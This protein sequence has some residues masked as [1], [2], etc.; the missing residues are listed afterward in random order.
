M[1]DTSSEYFRY[2]AYLHS[3]E[4]PSFKKACYLAYLCY[5]Y[6]IA[7]SMYKVLDLLWI[8]NIESVS[9]IYDRW[10]M[11]SLFLE[12][13]GS[14]FIKTYPVYVSQMEQLRKYDK[15]LQYANKTINKIHEGINCYI[16][17]ER[18]LPNEGKGYINTSG[19]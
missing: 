1:Y 17:L 5:L 18:Y 19:F 6:N 14:N 11:E 10:Y 13:D 12:Y 9:L 15:H 7:D 8:K 3:K 2:E 4:Y 16:V